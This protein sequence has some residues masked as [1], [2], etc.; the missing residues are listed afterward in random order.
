MKLKDNLLEALPYILVLCFLAWATANSD[1]R[2]EHTE[3][4]RH[5][6]TT[7]STGE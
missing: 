6:C 2:T 7:Y 4:G 3:C 5:S 1:K